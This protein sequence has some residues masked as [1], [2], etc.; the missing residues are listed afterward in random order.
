MSQKRARAA[1]RASSMPKS[2]RL[3]RPRQS[4]AQVVVLALEP[5]EP[6]AARSDPRQL[7]VARPRRTAGSTRRGACR[8]SSDSPLTAQAARRRTR[9]SSPASRK[10][11]SPSPSPGARRLWSTSA[12]GREHIE[13]AVR[14]DGLGGLERAAAGRRP[15]AGE[16]R[17]V[18]AR[19]RSSW[20]QAIA[21]A[22]GLLA[23]RAGRARRR[24]A[25]RAAAPGVGGKRSAA[26]RLIRAAA[27]S[28]AS[29]RPSSR[30][31]ISAT[32]RAFSSVSAKSGSTACAR[33]DEEP[34]RGVRRE[35]LEAMASPRGS[36]VGS[37]GT[38]YSCSAGEPQRRA[39]RGQHAAARGAAA[40][41]S[42]T[43]GAAGEEL[44]EVVEHEQ[45]LWPRGA[46]RPRVGQRLVSASCRPSACGDRRADERRVANGGEGDE[47]A[48]SRRP[49]ASSSAT[50]SAR[51]VLP[52]PPG[53]GQRD[54]ARVVATEHARDR[55][56][57]EAAPDQR[58]GRHRQVPIRFA[59]GPPAPRGQ[60]R[61]AGFRAQARGEPTPGSMPSSSSSAL[62]ASL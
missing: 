61:G 33:A 44:L 35:L 27:S 52:V 22:Q 17:L 1:T 39:A 36:G 41:S 54:E 19:S 20:L 5:L 2:A 59:A 43:S 51:R 49:G 50:A 7:A 26:T 34:H 46:P 31:Q 47:A 4:R 24:S 8:S 42:A 55:G 15:R 14:A 58:R 12:R 60:G 32:S 29:G 13:V 48:P 45:Q 56:D 23:R 40:S 37:G 6:R 38:G 21:V 11:G 62:R 25:G 18:R 10:R 53:P 30:R 9:G 28:I 57:L 3:L 16:E